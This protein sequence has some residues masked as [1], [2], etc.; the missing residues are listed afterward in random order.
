MSNEAGGIVE[1]FT[2]P[3]QNGNMI[4]LSH[5]LQ[6]HNGAVIAFYPKD[7]TMF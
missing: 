6:K 2:L 3:D 1:D 4:T 7:D 5:V